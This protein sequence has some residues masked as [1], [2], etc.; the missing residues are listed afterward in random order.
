MYS[1]CGNL[2]LNENKPLP[3]RISYTVCIRNF[4]GIIVIFPI[5]A[6]IDSSGCH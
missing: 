6:I 4:N 3:N 1:N 5:K 2:R